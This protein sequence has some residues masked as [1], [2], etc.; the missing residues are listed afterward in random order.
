M[1]VLK[2]ITASISDGLIPNT[3]TVDGAP[4]GYDCIDSSLWYAW[5]VQS[6][7]SAISKHRGE[8]ALRKEV[9]G[10]AAPALYG[11]IGAYRKGH[12][13]F[14]SADESGFL[15]VGTPNTQLT[16]M[17]VQINGR[18]VTPRNGHPVEIEA[19][20]YNT[21]AL[22]HHIAL[23]RKDPDPCSTKELAAMRTVFRKRFLL[24][25]GSLRDVWRSEEDGGPDNSVRPNQ[26]FAAALPF[27]VLEPEKAEGVV[28]IAREKLLTP[29]GLRT[30]SPDDPAFCPNYA[31]SPAERGRSYH[32]GTVWPWLLGVY[33]DALF[34][35]TEAVSA[36]KRTVM[37][38]V[39]TDF[40]NTISP[41]FT[42]HLSESCLGHISEI[43]SG[44]EPWAPHGS[45]AKAWS[46]A[47]VYRALL[48][49]RAADPKAYE[50]WEKH[51]KWRND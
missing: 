25:D 43:F 22:A 38:G 9:L 20:W 23:Q 15:D 19:L 11:I 50:R 6:L 33:A 47:E 29:F 31:G 28:K 39:V 48:L 4:S 17:N 10:F 8:A 30:L 36:G 46:E 12:I 42:R 35:T 24:P 51:L 7:L 45:I 32:Q 18:P 41:L 44:T 21:L 13:L 40:L 2:R 3:F 49:A 26:L 5:A 27:P 34:K 16:W 1:A 37:S 14:V